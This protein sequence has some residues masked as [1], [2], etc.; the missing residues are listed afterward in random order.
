MS[1][2]KKS[3]HQLTLLEIDIMTTADA[4]CMRQAIPAA[5]KSIV[6]KAEKMARRLADAFM[7]QGFELDAKKW[8]QRGDQWQAKL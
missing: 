1:V 8:H 5:E 6:R 7:N 2:K 4:I 3:K